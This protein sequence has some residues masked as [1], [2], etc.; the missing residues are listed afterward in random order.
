MDP[1]E[2]AKL[3]QSLADAYSSIYEADYHIDKAQDEIGKLNKDKPSPSNEKRKKAWQRLADREA[4]IPKNEYEK[5]VHSKG[6]KALKDMGHKPKQKPGA[7]AGKIKGM[8]RHLKKKYGSPN[9]A[10][11]DPKVKKRVD[12]IYNNML[13]TNKPPGD[14]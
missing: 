9:A 13:K 3:I 8:A 1:I 6:A 4:Q 11:K 7:E 12:G 10:A 14:D 5:K 2:E